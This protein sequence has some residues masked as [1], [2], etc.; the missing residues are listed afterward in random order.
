MLRDERKAD[1]LDR[2]QFCKQLMNTKEESGKVEVC[3]K[4]A[5]YVEASSKEGHLFGLWVGILR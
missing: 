1:K 4:G 2:Q 5:M 3:A